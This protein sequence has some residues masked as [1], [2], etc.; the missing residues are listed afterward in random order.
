MATKRKYE[1]KVYIPCVSVSP[2]QVNFYSYPL[3]GFSRS[4]RFTANMDNLIDNDTEGKMSMKARKKFEL[5]LNWLLFNAKPKRVHD[6]E[7]GKSF[8]FK[9]NFITLTLPATQQH[10]DQEIKDVCLNNF[11]TVARKAGLKNYIWRAE[12]QPATGNIH[13]HLI[14]DMFI[15][16]NDI[17]KWWNQSTQ[18]LGYIDAYRLKFGHRNPNSTDVHSV[19]HVRKLAPYLSKYCTKNRA[20]ACIGEL[21]KIKGQ[22]I[23]VLYKS[24]MYHKE[25]GGKKQGVVIGHILGARIRPIEGRLWACSQSLSSKKTII[26]DGQEHELRPFF[27]FVK[28]SD[29]YYHQSQY[30]D[31]YFGDVARESEV[32]FPQ[33]YRKMKEYFSN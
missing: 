26:F 23:E 15:H 27:E 8:S 22:V 32:Y 24:D 7:T 2:A 14:T 30:V 20:F 21:R 13:F 10:S 4:A 19:K 3:D 11:I 16:Y 18:L 9:V 17:R 5:A 28:Q 31:C 25:E 33:L 6:S 1:E 12:A 29:F